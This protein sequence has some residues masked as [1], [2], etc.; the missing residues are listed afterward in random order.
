MAEELSKAGFSGRVID[1]SSAD[2]AA[3]SHRFSAISE[4][5]AQYIAFPRTSEDVS[6][7]IVYANRFVLPHNFPL[8]I[9]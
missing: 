2:F 5:R 1:S 3:A 7:A 4:A 8:G 9:D 6:I